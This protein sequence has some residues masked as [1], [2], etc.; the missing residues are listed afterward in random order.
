MAKKYYTLLSKQGND[1]W[2]IEF[3]DYSR[4][5]VAQ[6]KEDMK[7]SWDGHLY[8][9][10]IICTNDDQASINEAVAKLSGDHQ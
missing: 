9:F 8:K 10:K 2:V 6:E 3:G 5:V 4:S 7:D 1:P